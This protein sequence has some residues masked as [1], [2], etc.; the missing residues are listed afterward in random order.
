[1]RSIPRRA[2][3]EP[4]YRKII[5]VLDDLGAA[6]LRSSFEQLAATFTDR[7][8]TFAFGGEERPFPLDL[9]PRVIA[10][11]EW[12]HLAAGVRQ[13]VLALEAFFD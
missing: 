13:R 8:V 2:Y 9:I 10:A 1:M 3:R 11:A 12:E 5:D 6:D 7:G 4:A